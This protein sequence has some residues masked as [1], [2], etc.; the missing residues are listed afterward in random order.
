MIKHV[1]GCLAALAIAGAALAQPVTA[2]VAPE[3]VSADAFPKLTA[4]YSGGVK[5]H[6]DLVFQNK[7]GFRPL[8]LDVYAAPGGAPKPLVI[9]V[10]GGG[11]MGGTSRNAAGKRASPARR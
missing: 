8:T 11:W 2:D 10:H 9:Y 6:P 7:Q 1:L 4:N 3:V 5:G